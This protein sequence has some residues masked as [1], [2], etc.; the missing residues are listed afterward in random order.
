M[1]SKFLIFIFTSVLSNVV[2]AESDYSLTCDMSG[3]KANVFACNSGNTSEGN[4]RYVKVKA[5]ER[6][7]CDSTYKLMYIYA[8][9]GHC[10]LVGSVSF[11]EVKD[12][13]TASF[14]E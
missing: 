7:D 2:F 5:C 12:F 6:T 11:R 10:K 8:A 14:R 9:A 4:N 13:C 1:R 3:S